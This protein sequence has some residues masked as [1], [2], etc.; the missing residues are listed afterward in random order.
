MKRKFNKE[1]WITTFKIIKTYDEMLSTKTSD[2]GF[3][4]HDFGVE[5]DSFG[6]LKRKKSFCGN[7]YYNILDCILCGNK[8]TRDTFH[9]CGYTFYKRTTKIK[10]KDKLYDKEN[11]LQKT[12]LK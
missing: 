12:Y 8:V 11:F 4:S 6:F 3:S 1:T 7:I 10:Y 2:I 9:T 5:V